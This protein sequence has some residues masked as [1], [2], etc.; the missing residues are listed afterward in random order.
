MNQP[1]EHACHGWP[2]DH[3]PPTPTKTIIALEAENKRL[4][5]GIMGH[6]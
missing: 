5:G 4:R 3:E 2:K 6:Y 1:N